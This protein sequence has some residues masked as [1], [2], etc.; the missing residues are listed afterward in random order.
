MDRHV[1]VRM[2]LYALSGMHAYNHGHACIHTFIRVHTD[3]NMHAY[4]THTLQLDLCT[5]KT[6]G[7]HTYIN[8]HIHT[9][10]RTHTCTHMYNAHTTGASHSSPKGPL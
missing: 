2:T 9:H 5:P 6:H 10:T 1:W 4:K 8:T 3:M 7:T